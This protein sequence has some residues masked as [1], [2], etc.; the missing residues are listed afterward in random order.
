MVDLYLAKD[1]GPFANVTA[2][3]FFIVEV[4]GIRCKSPVDW[5]LP[6]W[7]YELGPTN[8]VV[9]PEATSGSCP[10]IVLLD[11]RVYLGAARKSGLSAGL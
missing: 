6:F 1:L 8:L 10:L 9:E 3:Y 7:K 11:P 2:G 4:R 5:D